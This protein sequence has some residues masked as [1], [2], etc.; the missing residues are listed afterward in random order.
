MRLQNF[1]L[2]DNPAN[3]LANVVAFEKGVQSGYL[4]K[5]KTENVFYCRIHNVVIHR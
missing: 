4:S 5:T 3:Q 2:V 1:S